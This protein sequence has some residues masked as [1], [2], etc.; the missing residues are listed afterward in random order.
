MLT[1]IWVLVGLGLAFLLSVLFLRVLSFLIYLWPD[2]SL[3][4]PR[5]SVPPAYELPRYFRT[6]SQD[7][8]DTAARWPGWDGWYFFV[9]PEGAGQPVKM[10]RASLMT[11]L[12]GLNGIDD[13]RKLPAGLSPFGAAEY[14]TLIPQE[15]ASDPLI[16]AYVPKAGL[17]MS[18]NS[19]KVAL[20]GGRG[21]RG[22]V[23][24]RWPDY[25]MEFQDT[26]VGIEFLL[27]Y[28][29][30]NLVWWADVP[31][32]FTYFSAFGQFQG[33]LS[34]NGASRDVQGWGGFEHGCARKP[35]NFDLFFAPVRLV[36]KLAPA[37]KPL[38]Y[39]YEVFVGE[40]GFHGGFMFARGFGADFRNHGGFYL[41]GAYIPIRRVAIDYLDLAEPHGSS[42]GRGDVKFP[43]KWK[44]TAT[45]AEGALEYVA[46]GEWPPPRIAPN[47]IYHHLDLEGTYRGKPIRG[48]GYGEYVHM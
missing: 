31:G 7:E 11:G 36:Q 38:R 40:G 20:N 19:L 18:L 48:S 43:R 16:H 32:V 13:Y 1:V 26:Q 22:C 37:W 42:P 4:N 39:H 2:R 45:T 8:A 25:R 17:E 23:Q 5:D 46:T 35:F 34:C 44:V 3:R 47:M 27:S 33:T 15:K 41:D 9:I 21:R 30:S 12:Y 10:V 24:G 29:G 14:L 6:N 28:R